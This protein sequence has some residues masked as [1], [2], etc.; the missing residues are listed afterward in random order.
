MAGQSYA[1][2]PSDTEDSHIGSVVTD[3]MHSYLSVDN[4]MI[5]LIFIQNSQM[6]TQISV[7]YNLLLKNIAI[8]ICSEFRSPYLQ[9][10]F[11]ITM[12]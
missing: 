11:N 9:G 12:R 7:S 3:A 4:V 10:Y 8:Q 2:L 5:M 1:I 6:C